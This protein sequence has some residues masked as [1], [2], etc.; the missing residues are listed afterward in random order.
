VDDDVRLA[1]P[2]ARR[3]AGVW[4][5]AEMVVGAGPDA[6]THIDDAQPGY[7][8]FTPRSFVG[9]YVSAFAPREP[10]PPR[11]DDEAW[12]RNYTSFVSFGGT[13]TLREG[14]LVLRATASQNPNN[15][16]GRPFQSIDVTWEGE[17]TVW[18]VYT[19]SAG[20][21]NRTRLVRVAD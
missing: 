1:T 6:G 18:F 21:Q 14:V 19:N 4:K 7:Y 11:A 17:D 10:L 20:I 12:G 9:N 5:R 16:Q 15:M 13:F 2:D 3:L 8:I